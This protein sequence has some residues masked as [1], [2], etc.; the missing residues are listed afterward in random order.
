MPPAGHKS[1]TAGAERSMGPRRDTGAHRPPAVLWS[2]NPGWLG[3]DTASR[4]LHLAIIQ[5]VDGSSAAATQGRRAPVATPRSTRGFPPIGTRVS[6]APLVRRAE[7]PAH[8]SRAPVQDRTPAVSRT[9]R[10]TPCSGQFQLSTMKGLGKTRA[11][12]TRRSARP[13]RHRLHTYL[14]ETRTSTAGHRFR[15]SRQPG[16]NHVLA[17]TAPPAGTGDVQPLPGPEVLPRPCP[18][19]ELSSACLGLNLI[20]ARLLPE[21]LIAGRTIFGAMKKP[22]A[23]AEPLPPGIRSATVA[24]SSNPSQ[25]RAWSTPA[26]R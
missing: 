2:D 3:L 22:V 15:V 23:R 1:R 10:D 9:N 18:Q 26:P 16:H 7:H 6:A 25:L 8:R 12:R 14:R 24:V 11:L 21:D 5:F 20:V 4:R 19:G 13:R 17:R